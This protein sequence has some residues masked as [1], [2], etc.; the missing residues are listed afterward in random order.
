MLVFP[1]ATPNHQDDLLVVVL[2]SDNLERM[3]E[4]DPAEVKLKE[5][6]SGKNRH[7]LLQPTV[8]LCYEKDMGK[9]TKLANAGDIQALLKYLNRG[10]KFRPERGDHDR[11]PERLSDTN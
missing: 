1:I 3:Q 7:L 4:G 11:G 5:L 6:A 8:V 9:V 2:G 10:W